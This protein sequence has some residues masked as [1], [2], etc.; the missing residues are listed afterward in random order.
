VSPFERP[1]AEFVTRK[2]GNGVGKSLV[3]FAQFKV[4]GGFL[5]N[6]IRV[7]ES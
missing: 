7:T 4:H 5:D 2:T 1:R 6:A 3:F